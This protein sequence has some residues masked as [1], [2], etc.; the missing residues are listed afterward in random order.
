VKIL[1]VSSQEE[2]VQRIV[3]AANEAFEKKEG[4]MNPIVLYII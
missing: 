1:K 3:D 2:M 4:K